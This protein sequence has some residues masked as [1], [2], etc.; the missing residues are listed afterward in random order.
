MN[1]LLGYPHDHREDW[2]EYFGFGRKD[3]QRIFAKL[4]G[5]PPISYFDSM[6]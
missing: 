4:R 1:N 5:G 6:T 3:V 2:D